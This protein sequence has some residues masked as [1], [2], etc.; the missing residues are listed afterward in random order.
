MKVVSSTKSQIVKSSEKVSESST[1][2][3][4]KPL[5]QNHHYER[6]QQ[7]W[8]LLVLIAVRIAGDEQRVHSMVQIQ[9]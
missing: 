6:K 4:R 8:R 2:Q 5:P 9:H 1:L 3:P 7:T